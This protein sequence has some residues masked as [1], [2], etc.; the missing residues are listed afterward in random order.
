[1][2][3]VQIL[4]DFS[5]GD[6]IG[7]HVRLLNQQLEKCGYDTLVVAGH[8]AAGLQASAIP[9]QQYKSRNDDIVIY[10]YST[11]SKLNRAVTRLNNKLITNYHNIT[12]GSYFRPYSKHMGRI[13]DKARDDMQYLARAS[14][15]IIGDSTYNVAEFRKLIKE[16]PLTAIPICIDFSEYEQAP[17]TTVMSGTLGRTNILFVGRIA[18]NKCQERC[19]EDFAYYN[20][21][22][23]NKAHL[24][25]VGNDRGSE[26]YK[27]RLTDFIDKNE[28]KNVHFT[29]HISFAQMLAYYRTASIFLCESMHEG[30]CVPL[31][32]SMYFGIPIIARNTTA[33]SETL[34]N[35]GILLNSESPREVAS[36]IDG[37]LRDKIR[38]QEIR[39]AQKSQMA[40]CDAELVAQ[41]YI[42]VI[43]SI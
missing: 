20:S 24:Y 1:M 22:F 23:E 34:G 3:I 35:G 19:I 40:R 17:D 31:I 30:F 42:D 12:P 8:I 13:L 26:N 9:F 32:E 33:I 39:N 10:H 43:E 4:P 18:P 2:R 28:I 25:L 15:A 14:A 29:G 21:N 5:S 37:L 11:Y 38:I 6:A 27:N 16:V 7:N 36:V 41:Q